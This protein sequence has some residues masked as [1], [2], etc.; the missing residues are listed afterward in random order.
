MHPDEEVSYLLPY[1][2]SEQNCLPQDVLMTPLVWW[3]S[4]AVGVVKDFFR[5]W[6][7]ASS[8]PPALAGGI[9]LLAYT[10]F[11]FFFKE[12]LALQALHFVTFLFSLESQNSIPLPIL[13]HVCPRATLS[14]VIFDR[15]AT[16]MSF[17]PLLVVC[18]CLDRD[19]P[20]TSRGHR[21]SVL[22]LSWVLSLR[23]LYSASGLATGFIE[24]TYLLVDSFGYD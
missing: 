7:P 4:A 2:M 19:S 24:G 1:L 21:G 6:R 9:R 16:P 17:P 13:F 23:A 14:Y 12:R 3:L 22:R 11:D 18:I 15:Y 5:L 10:I 8:A 20:R